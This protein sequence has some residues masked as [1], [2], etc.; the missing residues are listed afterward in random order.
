MAAA[1]G[2][3]D[4]VRAAKQRLNEKRRKYTYSYDE[5]AH[6]P[7]LV[8]KDGR[9]VVQHP[10]T[11]EL[12]I[13]H[14]TKEKRRVGLVSTLID[15][16]SYYPVKEED[17][18]TLFGLE[19]W[20]KDISER[21]RVA[22][23][24]RA[25]IKEDLARI[26]EELRRRGKED[27]PEVRALKEQYKEKIH[28]QLKAINETATTTQFFN[29]ELTRLGNTKRDAEIDIRKARHRLESLITFKLVEDAGR[30]VNLGAANESSLFSNVFADMKKK[31]KKEYNEALKGT[32]SVFW[33]LNQELDYIYKSVV[34]LCFA[35]RTYT[36]KTRDELEIMNSYLGEIGKKHTEEIFHNNEGENKEF[37]LEIAMAYTLFKEVNETVKNRNDVLNQQTQKILTLMDM[38]K[39]RSWLLDDYE[40]H[41]RSI[42]EFLDQYDLI[43]NSERI[44]YEKTE[45]LLNSKR[46][47]L[48]VAVHQTDELKKGLLF[49][50][51][52]QETGKVGLKE[53][54]QIAAMDW[55]KKAMPLIA[56]CAV[57]G[58]G[59]A[60]LGFGSAFL[61]TG[62]L[63]GKGFT[64]FSSTT[65]VMSLM[66]EKLPMAGELVSQTADHLAA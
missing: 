3:L 25:L 55:C 20:Y 59:L 45:E 11:G 51:D 12:C 50:R 16:I 10:K 62:F 65:G 42:K 4:G 33:K 2:D 52:A 43:L 13:E 31:E 39:M 14:I 36:D 64:I 5:I 46:K 22:Q 56:V 41:G 54:M 21:K 29:R 8:T 34:K 44:I 1:K 63:V 9:R 35:L 19:G 66:V 27:S 23:E 32:D 58:G 24:E 40:F 60:I 28:I 26:T 30:T 53:G 6:A 37:D 38:N 18:I 47:M 49:I 17:T 57:I 48:K 61:S 7:V 15:V